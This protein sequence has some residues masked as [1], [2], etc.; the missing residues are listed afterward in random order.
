MT[1]I[2]EVCNSIYGLNYSITE[3]VAALGE[4]CGFYN[5]ARE[6]QRILR[7]IQ[8]LVSTVEPYLNGV[9]VWSSL[10]EV[11][12]TLVTVLQVLSEAGAKGPLVSYLQ[13][14]HTTSRFSAAAAQLDAALAQLQEEAC[15]ASTASL[16]GSNSLS[17]SCCN[18]SDIAS[19]SD[20]A[21][22]RDSC[23]S[24]QIS[25]SSSNSSSSGAGL[26]D[27]QPGKV[28]E[29]VQEELL[30]V[31]EQL[32][33]TCFDLPVAHRA[34]LL[35]YRHACDSLQAHF[36]AMQKSCGEMLEATAHARQLSQEDFAAAIAELQQE[37]ELQQQLLLLLQAEPSLSL[38]PGTLPDGEP[39]AC[40]AG[41]SRSRQ[42]TPPH[43]PLPHSRLPVRLT[44]VQQCRRQQH[45]LRM[46]MDLLRAQHVNVECEAPLEFICP[47]THQVIQDPVLL[48]DTGHSYERKALEEWWA[49]GHHFCP[50]T[51]VPLRRLSTSP[52]HSLRSAIGRWR[53]HSDMHLSF[54][55][56]LNTLA[57]EARQQHNG[58]GPHQKHEPQREVE[59]TAAATA[60]MR[61]LGVPTEAPKGDGVQVQAQGLA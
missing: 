23:S 9:R 2:S 36:Q 30:G 8:A 57:A 20:E 48:H 40:A 18:C 38:G 32:R 6:L 3:A 51:G 22:D 10:R 37:V 44:Q 1:S 16:S 7:R 21:A 24:T 4:Q 60:S 53:L 55:P 35:R 33:S 46:L 43:S 15:K 19:N 42:P 47:L 29:E 61:L 27:R 34:N 49:K 54:R 28:P 17:A 11:E 52:N 58:A 39:S 5:E 12:G 31:R 59:T 50:R 26:G 13:A 56:V 41:A 45:H 25:S 14:D